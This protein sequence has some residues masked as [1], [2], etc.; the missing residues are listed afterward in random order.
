MYSPPAEKP[1]ELTRPRGV[2]LVGQ[3]EKAVPVGRWYW[4]QFEQQ[5]RAL[6]SLSCFCLADDAEANSSPDGWNAMDEIGV[7]KC[8]SD[9]RGLSM[10]LFPSTPADTSEFDG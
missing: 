5:R 9:L 8:S 7:V 2:A 3:L 4:G 10:L 1:S 6:T